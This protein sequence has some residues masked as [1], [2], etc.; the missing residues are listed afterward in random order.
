MSRLNLFLL[1][2]LVVACLHLVFVSHETRRLY[3]ELDRAAAQERSLDIEFERLKAEAQSQ[4]TPSRVEQSAKTRLQ[5]RQ[6]T[7]AVTEYVQPPGSL[8][9]AGGGA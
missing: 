7:P 5:M 8:P 3:A 9:V 4:A 1:V 6:A 2:I